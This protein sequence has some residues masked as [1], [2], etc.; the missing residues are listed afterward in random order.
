MMLSYD[1]SYGFCDLLTDA[2]NSISK[3][4]FQKNKKLLITF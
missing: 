2:E 4:L 1:S 3:R